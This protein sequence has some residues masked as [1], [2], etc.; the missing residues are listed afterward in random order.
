MHVC[1]STQKHSVGERCGKHM[2]GFYLYATLIY[3]AEQHSVFPTCVY[4]DR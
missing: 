4:N 3:S 1:I 2:L